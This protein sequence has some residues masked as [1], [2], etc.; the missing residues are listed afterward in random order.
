MLVDVAS[1][2]ANCEQQCEDSKYTQEKTQEQFSLLECT[3]CKGGVQV[4]AI[5]V[6]RY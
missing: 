6:I 1:K 5:K 4:K 2:K 3:K